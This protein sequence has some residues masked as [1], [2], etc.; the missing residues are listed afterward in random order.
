M[1]TNVHSSI[2]AMILIAQP[3]IYGVIGAVL[4]HAALDILGEHSYGDLKRT[5]LVEGLFLLSF[6][7]GTYFLGVFWLALAGAVLGNLFDII[8]KFRHYVLNER[9]I[10]F[11]HQGYWPCVP[12][13]LFWTYGIGIILFWGLLALCLIK[14]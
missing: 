6:L 5:I 14:Q 11:C 3:N 2:G 4:S 7:I 12:L 13:N 8:D 1:Y 9:E 10:I